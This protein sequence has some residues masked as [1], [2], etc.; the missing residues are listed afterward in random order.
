MPTLRFE[1][2]LLRSGYAR[3]ACIDEA[4]RGALCGPVS[5]GVVVIT[6]K[7]KPAPSGVRDSKLLSAAQREE[8]A[9][10]IRAWANHAVGMASPAEIDAL[11]IMAAMRL[12]GQR[13]LAA[14]SVQPDLIL[15]DGSYDYLSHVGQRSLFEDEPL[16]TFPEVT[17]HVKADLHC[18]GV[19]AASILA[20]TERDAVMTALGAEFPAY[21]WEKNKGYAAPEHLAALAEYGPSVHHRTSWKLPS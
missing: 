19:A 11:G 3:I 21:G 8:L 9:P 13:A 20:K 4:G 12:A 10:R 5:L 15:L 18:A 2:Q 1:R 16:V 7:T 6:S 14:L 17:T